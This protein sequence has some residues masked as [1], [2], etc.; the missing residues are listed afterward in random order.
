MPQG[1]GYAAGKALK[2]GRSG[3]MSGT[4]GRAAGR[5]AKKVATAERERAGAAKQRRDTAKKTVRK[6]L[7]AAENRVY[8]RLRDK[9]NRTKAEDAIL[10]K[11]MQRRDKKV[12]KALKGY[13]SSERAKL[14]GSVLNKAEAREAASKLPKR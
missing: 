6:G 2:R 13:F 4:F 9:K 1:I 12:R 3:G 10:K 14:Y 8:S 7:T 5:V 11:L